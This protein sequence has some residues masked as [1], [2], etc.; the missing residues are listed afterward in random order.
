MSSGSKSLGLSCG[1]LFALSASSI[2]CGLDG[3][4]LLSEQQSPIY[5][6]V[7]DAD[8][9][10]PWVVDLCVPTS[11]DPN[12]LTTP[13]FC[14][15]VLIDKRW[16]LTTK[17]CVP[18]T[19]SIVVTYR[20]RTS[21]GISQTEIRT[22]SPFSSD[23]P[24]D[25]DL[26][27]LRLPSEFTDPNH[28]LV[29]AELPLYALGVG[30][31]GVIASGRVGLANTTI[32][33]PSIT[34]LSGIGF[35]GPDKFSASSSTSSMCTA[36]RGGGFIVQS[37]GRNY[38]TGLVFTTPGNCDATNVT[39]DAVSV[40]AHLPFIAEKLGTT[41]TATAGF[42]P[43][44]HVYGPGLDYGLPSTWDTAVGDFNGDGKSDYV[45][46]NASSAMVYFGSTA[47]TFTQGIP[48]YGGKS[49][50]NWTT[51]VGNFNK[52]SGGTCPA[53]MDFARLGP[54]G[55][56]VY[57]GKS[58]GT[59]T[60][61]SISYGGLNFGAPS[62][63]QTA[64]GDFDGDGRTDYQRLGRTGAFMYFGNANNTFTS[65]FYAYQ[66]GYDFHEP[67]PFSLAVGDFN[68]D[69]RADYARIWGY[70]AYIYSGT[71]WQ[72]FNTGYQDY[73]GTSVPDL[74]TP[75]PWETIPGNFNGDAYADYARL[76]ATGAWIFY[77]SS[78]GLGAGY[79]QSYGSYNF[80]LPSNYKTI[81][82][83]FN[84]DGKTDYG[85]LGD[86]GG[87]FYFG[88]ATLGSFTGSF[89]EYQRHFGQPSSFTS[90]VG[91][92]NGDSKVDYARLGGVLAHT[93]MHN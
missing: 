56:D 37:G 71:Q 9:K 63:W 46:V 25:G 77:G 36:D 93:F 64:V 62:L 73:S 41:S 50:A 65:S 80:G 52:L 18:L 19:A 88:S 44:A 48:P 28:L 29:P 85:R 39:F 55:M 51:I 69:G 21:S 30:Q 15:G 34:S 84:F 89:Q 90:V 27:M 57:Y 86:T 76:G 43:K 16:V 32:A 45:R 82:G 58:D 31:S 17:N 12:C 22:V 40:L 75:S 54:T 92:F 20:R 61:V 49:Y 38:V 68:G 7:S 24:L 60:S 35:D 2:G 87:Y 10:Y 6:G 11:G 70:G 74:G 66:S 23:A 26:A 33:A 13:P 42:A 5:A 91:D 78:S 83:D 72:S 67:T 8:Y 59:F 14:R 4:E 79:W 47:G 81:V 1:V 3:D 53:C